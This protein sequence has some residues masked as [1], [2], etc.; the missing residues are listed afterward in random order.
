MV[1]KTI[2]KDVKQWNIIIYKLELIT[3]YTVTD[4]VRRGEQDKCYNVS[5]ILPP[6]EGPALSFMIKR[7]L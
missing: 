5:F 2:P 1:K 7:M 6:A 3:H 4:S